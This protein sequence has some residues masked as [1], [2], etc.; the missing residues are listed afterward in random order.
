MFFTGSQSKKREV[1]LY[2]L[3]YYLQI[4]RILL[5]KKQWKM[6][7]EFRKTIFCL[8][9]HKHKDK[10]TQLTSRH[11]KHPEIR[12]V[13]SLYLI[14]SVRTEYSIFHVLF[15]SAIEDMRDNAGRVM[16]FT[17]STRAM[18]GTPQPTSHPNEKS[19][20]DMYVNSQ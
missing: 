11:S 13:R 12:Q 5:E 6:P 1:F 14:F 20:S 8:L 9:Y 3:V 15:H 2:I 16:T 19:V 10:S 17:P 7:K 4:V 18:N